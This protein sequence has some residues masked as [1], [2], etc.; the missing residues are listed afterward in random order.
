MFEI[1]PLISIEADTAFNSL[2]ASV[3]DL[4][5]FWIVKVPLFVTV[6]FSPK[7]IPPAPSCVMVKS[8]LPDK[9]PLIVIDVKLPGSLAQ[10]VAPEVTGPLWIDIEPLR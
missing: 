6:L 3:P 2:A 9:F 1:L 5:P 8:P 4:L 7:V 10:P